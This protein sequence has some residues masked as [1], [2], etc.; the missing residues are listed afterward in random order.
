MQERSYF[1]SFE[2]IRNIMDE[3]RSQCP[4]DQK[5]TI[6]TLRQLTIEETYEL[7]DAIT[8]KDW[9]AIKEELGDLLLH[10]LFYA[11]IAEEEKC[12]SI[13]DVIEQVCN[14]LVFRHPHIYSF[15]QVNGEEDV[16]KNW[17][18]LKLQEGKKSVLSGV[19]NGLPAMTKALRI[20]E[21]AKQAGFEWEISSQVKDKISEELLE[22]EA[23]LIEGQSDQIEDEF[24][25]VL[26]S[27]IN[28]ARFLNIDPENALERTNLKFKHRFMSMEETLTKGGKSLNEYTL[29]EM[30]AEWNH[31]KKREGVKK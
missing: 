13:D 19:P 9:N 14:K 23:A 30:D 25:D 22:L 17:E 26:F 11:K 16:K 6:A 21:K 31:I 5:Q 12:F 3:L 24:G 2:R 28:Y 18:K 29:E 4:W 27:L 1:T 8:K 15:T 7:T 20:Q 10:I